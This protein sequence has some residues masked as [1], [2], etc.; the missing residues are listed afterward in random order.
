MQKDSGANI[1]KKLVETGFKMW[2]FCSY[3]VQ[4]LELSAPKMTHNYW[5]FVNLVFRGDKHRSRK[6]L[7][8]K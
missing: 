3:D 2:H 8:H 4:F 1:D 5:T 6:I 7:I